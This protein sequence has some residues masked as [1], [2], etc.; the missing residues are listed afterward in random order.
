M[1]DTNGPTGEAQT[2]SKQSVP[3]AT[4]TTMTTTMSC[5]TAA[6]RHLGI[7]SVARY[8]LPQRQSQNRRLAQV[9][10]RQS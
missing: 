6:I 3:M 1:I 7:I 4:K 10:A 8:C 5:S 2:D 9:K